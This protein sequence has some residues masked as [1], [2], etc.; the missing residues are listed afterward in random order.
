M[1]E[2][3]A[4]TEEAAEEAAPTPVSKAL[5]GS[6]AQYSEVLKELGFDDPEDWSKFTNDEWQQ[7]ENELKKRDVPMGHIFKIK[8]RFG[9]GGS[10][11]QQQL[12]ESTSSGA[13][14]WQ[15]L[16]R[17]RAR[18]VARR[19]PTLQ[20][21]RRVCSTTH[22]QRGAG[23]GVSRSIQMGGLSV[24]CF[25]IAYTAWHVLPVLA[26]AR[27]PRSA[28]GGSASSVAIRNSAVTF[29]HLLGIRL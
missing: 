13:T 10:S 3:A 5:G 12:P 21:G 7:L 14:T 6:A 22:R 9:I 19:S 26:S 23:G 29:Y 2:A 24:A 16:V 25:N 18:G 15:T 17:R 20:L 4:S 11:T 1:A 28:S 27:P 8:R